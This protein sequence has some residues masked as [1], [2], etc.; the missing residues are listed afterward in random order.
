[1]K[2]YYGKRMLGDVS[3][4]WG[5]GL[6]MNGTIHLSKE[7]EKLRPF[8]DWMVDEAHIG[9]E[10]PFSLDFLKSEKWHLIDDD[11]TKH[12]IDVPAI[13]AAEHSIS[14]RWRPLT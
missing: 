14:W 5:E 12:G 3:E 1:M 7:G 9:E 6:W 10:P 8:F 13:H 2:L 4:P 11:G